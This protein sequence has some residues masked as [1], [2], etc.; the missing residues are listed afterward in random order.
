MAK[1]KE[2]Q[3]NPQRSL[4]VQAAELVTSRA[5]N[6][7]MVSEAF[8]FDPDK[9]E[10][11][12]G[13]LY[14]TFETINVT[15]EA[16]EV[17]NKAADATREEYY[18]DPERNTHDALVAALDRANN[19]LASLA[20]QGE[21]D[22]V[23]NF[24]AA[25]ASFSGSNLHI[26]TAG[27]GEV[28]LARKGHL[29]NIGQ[30]MSSKERRTLHTFTT[31]ADGAVMEN[32]VV[33]LSTP[34][35]LHLIPE[36]RLNQLI[37]GK[38]P[39]TIVGLL[40]SLLD[41]NREES[42]FAA[43]VL[44][45]VKQPERIPAPEVP[46]STP[47]RVNDGRISSP[48]VRP[49]TP[50]TTKRSIWQNTA[51]VALMLTTTIWSTMQTHIFPFVATTSKQV[52]MNTKRISRNI[53]N[54]ITLW[55]QK[56]R[57]NRDASPVE[58]L[59]SHEPSEENSDLPERISIQQRFMDTGNRI[60][61]FVPNA[62]NRLSSLPQ[63]TKIFILLTIILGILLVGSVFRIRH[64]R[65][66]EAAIQQANEILQEA[67]SLYNQ[68]EAAL[69]YDDREQARDGI[70]QALH[71]LQS[72]EGTPYY[73]EQREDLKSDI[74]R[75]RD[76]IER[77][78]RI[79]SPEI[80]GDFGEIAPDLKTIGM[81][82]IRNN[83]YT[84]NAQNNAIYELDTETRE[85][86]IVSQ[87]SQGIGYFRAVVAPTGEQTL[88][89]STDTPGIAEFDTVRGD[90]LRKEI[91]VPDGIREFR[92]IGTFGNRLY[93]VAPEKNQIYSYAKTLAG[94]ADP[95]P[96]MTDTT[97]A[98][99]A[100]VAMGIDGN[101]YLLFSN[102]RIVKLLRG[103]PVEFEQEELM[104]PMEQPTRLFINEQI[105]RLYI[106]DPPTKRVVV[107]DTLGGLSRQFS[108]P[109]ATSLN[110][111][112]VTDNETTLYVLDETRVYRIEL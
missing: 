20:E 11:L 21:G 42:S 72:I 80:A 56:R 92:N 19:V 100:A 74:Q 4:S 50:I 31:T 89:F 86:S 40:R 109:N 111:I 99:N 91:E 106:L 88:L 76:R 104:T 34:Q 105:R 46:I 30:G 51:R 101:I 23:D 61:S 5:N 36:D 94:Y 17:L 52:W 10:E 81:A 71:V 64:T 60:Q 108:F 16:L 32:D 6:G 54:S 75:I 25:V 58:S 83:V 78:V 57:N 98:T 84:F 112:A 59:D 69:M 2:N 107:Y 27:S 53:G 18:N 85:T 79:E 9:G 33:I 77:I 96:W 48:T 68:A 43:L 24:H 103:A 87:T 90:L 39:A 22:F 28:L 35:L 70:I 15:E 44:Q 95:T 97:V 12:L 102:G 38:D 37:T 14:A 47:R 3:H 49:R 8:I 29:T 45:F 13:S 66:N 55:I 110:D 67:R 26:S 82:I 1:E 63:S 73:E 62:S 93:I 7:P 41:D 65:E